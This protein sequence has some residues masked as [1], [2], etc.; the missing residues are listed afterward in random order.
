MVARQRC[1]RTG[2][3]QQGRRTADPGPLS[4]IRRE[5]PGSLEVSALTGQGLD[6]LLD[7]LDEM[8]PDPTVAVDAV[9]PFDRGDLV[10]RVPPWVPTW[11]SSTGRRAQIRA[12]V[13]ADLAAAISAAQTE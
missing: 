8:L 2:G 11:T 12:R 5:L 4:A 1:R 3:R 9:V 10:S 13:P 7:R 6:V